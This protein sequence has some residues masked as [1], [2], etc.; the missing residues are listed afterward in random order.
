MLLGQS[1]FQSVLNRLEDEQAETENASAEGT[2]FR[3]RGFGAGF[4][5]AEGRPTAA[6]ADTSAYFDHL[7]EWLDEKPEAQPEASDAADGA[8][9]PAAPIMPDYLERLTEAEIIED[10][11]ISQQHTEAEL[12]EKRRQFAKL[13]HPDRVGPEFRENATTRMK[14]AN[15]L[16]DRA[17]SSLNRV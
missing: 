8:H 3:I 1:I 17:L 12:N 13:N 4:V 5:V 7:T 11:A 2:D 9:A 14:I 16:I 15:L 6:D 10:L